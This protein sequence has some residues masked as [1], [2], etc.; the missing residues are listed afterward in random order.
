MSDTTK[1]DDSALDDAVGGVAGRGEQGRIGS[2]QGRDK[3]VVLLLDE[4]DA[5]KSQPAAG[6][7]ADTDSRR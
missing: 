1:L 7:A 2:S 6:A 5:L 3:G 4:A